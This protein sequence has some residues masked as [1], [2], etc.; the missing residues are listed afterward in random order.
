M[1]AILI[2]LGVASGLAVSGCSAGIGQRGAHLRIGEL[3]IPSAHAEY[4]YGDEYWHR[5]HRHCW[6]ECRHDRCWTECD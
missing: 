2:A 6:R 3:M 1:K 5:H 4:Y